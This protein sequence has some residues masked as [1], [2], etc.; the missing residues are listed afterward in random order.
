MPKL[1]LSKLKSRALTTVS[2]VKSA[3]L[4]YTG[5][6]WLLPKVLLRMLKSRASTF[7]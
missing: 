6:P 7:L 3:R 5:C 2:P 1:L 4:S